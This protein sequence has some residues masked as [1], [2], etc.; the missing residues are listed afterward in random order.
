MK[1]GKLRYDIWVK[2]THLLSKS[3]I[4]K[5]YIWVYCKYQQYYLFGFRFMVMKT[6]PMS[7]NGF[8]TKGLSIIYLRFIELA[9]HSKIDDISSIYYE[10]TIIRLCWSF[11]KFQNERPTCIG[12]ISTRYYDIRN[13]I[14]TRHFISMKGNSIQHFYLQ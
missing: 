10:T 6:T 2:Y 12:K 8:E 9:I 13:S 14:F 7:W 1:I 11:R 3:F 5:G 4:L